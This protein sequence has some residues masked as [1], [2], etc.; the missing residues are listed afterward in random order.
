MCVCVGLQA[1][2]HLYRLIGAKH[3][4]LEGLT[5][6]HLDSHPDLLIPKDFDATKVFSKEELFEWA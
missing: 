5:M 3:L 1:L 6:L 4:P 2:E